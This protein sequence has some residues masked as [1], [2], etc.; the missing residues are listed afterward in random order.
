MTYD[1]LPPTV[2]LLVVLFVVFAGR[3][4]AI[5][6]WKCAVNLQN[7]QYAAWNATHPTEPP[8]LF[9]LSYEQCLAECGSGL[10]DIDWGVFSQT[11]S[12]WLLPW[13]ALMFQIPFGAEGELRTPFYSWIALDMPA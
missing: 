11:F 8:P 4:D 13:I 7:Q 10:G 12:T 3:V 6:L 5:E 1:A 2:A 9:V